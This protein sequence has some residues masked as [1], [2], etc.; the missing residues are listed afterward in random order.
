MYLQVL[1]TTLGPLPSLP[2]NEG[3]VP[4]ISVYQECNLISLSLNCLAKMS[5]V[6]D[7]TVLNS[8]GERGFKSMIVKSVVNSYCI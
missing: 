6:S 1:R 7:Q 3:I 2:M 4:G 5:L 8:R